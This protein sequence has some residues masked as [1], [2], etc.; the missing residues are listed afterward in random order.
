MAS[1]LQRASDRHLRGNRDNL[2]AVTIERRHAAVG[3]ERTDCSLA[4][5]TAEV[6]GPVRRVQARTGSRCTLHGF[7]GRSCNLHSSDTDVCQSSVRLSRVP[8]AHPTRAISQPIQP[9]PLGTR[10]IQEA[11]TSNAPTRYSSQLT[12]SVFTVS[13]LGKLSTLQNRC[14]R[15]PIAMTMP[16]KCL[17]DYRIGCA[18]KTSCAAELNAVRASSIC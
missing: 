4:L 3:P 14:N 10:S 15:A 7:H 2:L 9:S 12:R 18:R 16:E 1:L 17:C 8:T 6:L 5:R 13:V 11:N